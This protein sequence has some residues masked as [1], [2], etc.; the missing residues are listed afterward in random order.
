MIVHNGIEYQ[1]DHPSVGRE[2]TLN[3][4]KY[5]I[6]GWDAGS[7][8]FL[9]Y[10]STVRDN[11]RIGTVVAQA[12][13]PVPTTDAKPVPT[14]AKSQSYISPLAERRAINNQKRRFDALLNELRSCEPMHLFILQYLIG[15]A[16]K[17]FSTHQLASNMG[18]SSSTLINKPPLVLLRKNL[19]ARTGSGNHNY[20]YSAKGIRAMLAEEYPALDVE[21]LIEQILRI[22]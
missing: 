18:Y 20:R 12:A 5:R 4:L 21:K 10:I 3:G 2:V 9:I 16:D 1:V 13:F 11:K 6:A 17:E 14:P 22:E 19:I 8:R 15:H 7:E